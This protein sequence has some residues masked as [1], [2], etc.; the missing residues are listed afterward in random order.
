MNLLPPN[1][2]LVSSGHQLVIAIVKNSILA[3]LYSD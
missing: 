1:T 3:I 2:E